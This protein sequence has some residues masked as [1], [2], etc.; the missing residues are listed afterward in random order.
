VTGRKKQPQRPPWLDD[1]APVSDDMVQAPDRD[2]P[3]SVWSKR[4]ITLA[5]WG[6][7]MAGGSLF[8]AFAMAFATQ[9]GTDVESKMDMATF[10]LRTAAPVSAVVALV[11]LSATQ[12]FGSKSKES[13]WT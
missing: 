9:D 11:G 6:G 3:A 4:W 1:A 12:L 13:N 5:V 8:C 7:G 10:F 2:Q